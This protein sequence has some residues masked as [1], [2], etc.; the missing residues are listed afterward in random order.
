MKRLN[1]NNELPFE[2]F[3]EFIQLPLQQDPHSL[4]LI[5]RIFI[6]LRSGQPNPFGVLLQK[7]TG[8]VFANREAIMHWRHIIENKKGMEQKLGRTVGIQI[9]A[10]DYFTQQHATEEILF[11]TIEKTED[12]AITKTEDE[13]IERVYTPGYHLEKLKEE[14]LRSKRY[15][16]ALSAILLDIDE[17]RKVNDMLSHKIGDQ[18]LTIIVKIIKKTIR[19]VDILSRYSGDRFMLILPNTNKREAMELAERLRNNVHERT[20]RLEGLSGGVT[21]TLSVGQCSKDDSSNDF[22][23]RLE[24]VLLEGKKKARNSVYALP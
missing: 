24:G 6:E 11:Q 3:K 1:M 10:M 16:H 9:A 21:I 7:L 13:W 17:F 2:G 23:K 5:K 20:N 19:N 12:K 4:D 14:I 18:V 8:K 15:K 22:L